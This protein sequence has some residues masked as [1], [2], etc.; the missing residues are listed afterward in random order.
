MHGETLANYPDAPE[1]R[2]RKPCFT[3]PDDR[4]PK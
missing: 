3:V 4:S 1:R 2:V